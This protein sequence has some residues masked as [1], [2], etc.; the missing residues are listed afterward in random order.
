MNNAD[1]VAGA[2]FIPCP[3]YCDQLESG[4]GKGNQATKATVPGSIPWEPCSAKRGPFANARNRVTGPE[5]SGRPVNKFPSTNSHLR[6]AGVAVAI[7]SGVRINFRINTLIDFESFKFRFR[8][9]ISSRSQP[10]PIELPANTGRIQGI[11]SRRVPAVH[12]KADVETF[13]P[14]RQT[15]RHA[16]TWAKPSPRHRVPPSQPQ[17]LSPLLTCPQSV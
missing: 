7:R 9:F 11:I 8:T 3:I 16:D 15:R 12:Q 6:T 13:P 14:S 1:R 2:Y 17:S 10:R 4:S 5:V